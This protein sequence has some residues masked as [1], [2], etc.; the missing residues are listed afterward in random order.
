[1]TNLNVDTFNLSLDVS[2]VYRE[3][4]CYYFFNLS[5]QML[6]KQHIIRLVDFLLCKLCFLVAYYTE[7][8]RSS[9]SALSKQRFTAEIGR[10][11]FPEGL[12]NIKAYNS[13]LTA[14]GNNPR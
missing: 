8:P 4:D 7:M 6:M 13:I 2:F 3:A 9:Q 10:V 14:N 11:M 1:M 5:C 12:L